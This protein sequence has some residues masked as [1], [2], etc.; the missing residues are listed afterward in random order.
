MNSAVVNEDATAT[1]MRQL[2]EE[3]EVLKQ[4]LLHQ[5]ALSPGVA[6]VQQDSLQR[7]LAESEQLLAVINETWEEKLEKTRELQDTR[8]AFLRD[9][10]LVMGP[11]GL[12]GAANDVPLGSA[13]GGGFWCL[14][15]FVFGWSIIINKNIVWGRCYGPALDS[16]FAESQSVDDPVS[17]VCFLFLC[18]C[19]KR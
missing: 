12:P 8:M 10:G 6:S 13:V 2:T 19:L 15:C 1:M 16:V 14:F 5:A 7:Q 3:I 11:G 18:V 17:H 4:Q 9:L